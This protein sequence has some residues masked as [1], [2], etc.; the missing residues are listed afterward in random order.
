MDWDDLLADADNAPTANLTMDVDDATLTMSVDVMADFV[1]WASADN[2]VDGYG[3]MYLIDFESHDAA[4]TSV[5]SVGT[6]ANRNGAMRTGAWADNWDYSADADRGVDSGAGAYVGNRFWDLTVKGGDCGMPEWAG[7]FTWFDLLNCTNV[8]G[9][10]DFLTIEESDE[11]VNM[12][13]AVTVNL[14]SPLGLD[15]DNGTNLCLFPNLEICANRDKFTQN[16]NFMHILCRCQRSKQ[17]SFLNR[18][19]IRR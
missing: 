12:S 8:A 3:M 6:C 18:Q 4:S 1:G 9:D 17:I 10:S 2:G 13:G 5:S 11:W 15:S 14:I 7:S 16:L 19:S